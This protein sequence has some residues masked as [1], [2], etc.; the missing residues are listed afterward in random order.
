M[1]E[2]DY[3]VSKQ[4][5]EN[6]MTIRMPGRD[7]WESGSEMNEEEITVFMDQFRLILDTKCSGIIYT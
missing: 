6:G 5:F 2:T 3:M 4:D 7:D 1:Q